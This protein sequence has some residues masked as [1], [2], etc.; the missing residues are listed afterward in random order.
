M[1]TCNNTFLLRL[2]MAIIFLSHSLHGIF[3]G[4]D[5]NNFGDLFLNKIGFAP[6]G[7]YISWGIILFQIVG[8][9]LLLINKYL[10]MG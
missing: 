1:K 6:F 3:N 9:V 10:K 5:V 8:S 7:I 2:A 4:N